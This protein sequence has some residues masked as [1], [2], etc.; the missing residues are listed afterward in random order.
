MPGE[1]HD[2]KKLNFFLYRRGLFDPEGWREQLFPE[3]REGINKKVIEGRRAA[4]VNEMATE[5]ENRQQM[6]A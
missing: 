1:T 5:I 3:F 2:I 6:E 4:R